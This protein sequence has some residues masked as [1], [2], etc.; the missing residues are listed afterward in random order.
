MA[1]EDSSVQPSLL[2]ALPDPCLQAVLQCCAADD[3]RTLF[4]AAR[5][6]SRLQK[7]AELAL[8][9]MYVSCTSQQQA[10]SAL[11]FLGQHGE[12]VG[13]I[14][15]KGKDQ[16]CVFPHTPKDA[17]NIHQLPPSLQPSNLSFN[18]LRLQ[19]QPG[20]C[21]L[22]VLGAA[23]GLAAL[24]RM[25]I[26]SCRLLD[27]D[28][29]LA[30]ALSRL[31]AGLEHLCLAPAA[32]TGFGIFPVRV[33]Q[34][35][36]Q[37]TYLELGDVIL[38]GLGEV[39]PTLQAMTRLVDL[40]LS[41]VSVSH[42][43]GCYSFE[44][45]S[46]D[47]LS[48]ASQ[49]TRLA[50]SNCGFETGAL[51]LPYQSRLRHLDIEARDYLNRTG[52]D[53]SLLELPNLQQMPHLTHLRLCAN[54]SGI[55]AAAFTV[56]AANSKLQHLD[57][58][59]C[60]LPDG[61]WPYIFPVGGLPHLQK[62]NVSYVRQESSFDF[63]FWSPIP[64][65]SPTS[66]QP[67]YKRDWQQAQAPDSCRIVSCCPGLVSLEMQGLAGD[68]DQLGSWVKSADRDKLARQVRHGAKIGQDG[69]CFRHKRGRKNMGHDTEDVQAWAMICWA[70][71]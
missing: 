47:V 24:K 44:V 56:L 52:R 28:E 18:R 70:M 33:L 38:K 37:L 32:T 5:A 13:S 23:A 9:S 6:H 17:V 71:I 2:L 46:A 43:D 68:S 27:G 51:A 22:G 7:A 16:R 50:V 20:D 11:M 55:P 14:R 53:D 30:A 49:L 3:Q 45:I 62:L 42:P 67:I 40:R 8:D 63:P 15:L 41:K 57:I 1:R 31:P 60:E 34:P 66:K 58:S 19:L 25:E 21:F 26:N 10:D 64:G 48:C 4:N 39:A 69:F 29:A 12:H 36:Q 35:L 54:L 61:V 59:R 65:V